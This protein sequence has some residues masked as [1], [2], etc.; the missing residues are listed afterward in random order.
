[1]LNKGQYPETSPRR[2]E[3][4]GNR[5][6][7]FRD[8]FRIKKSLGLSRSLGHTSEDVTPLG[9]RGDLKHV[10][11]TPRR[12]ESYSGKDDGEERTIP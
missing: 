5:N 3:I 10:D 9:R 6:G 1:M 7:R 8:L 12:R 2:E 11:N 4:Q